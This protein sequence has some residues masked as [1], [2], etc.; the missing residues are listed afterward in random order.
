MDL[1]FRELGGDG[2]P[3]VI[4]H[5]LFGSSQNWA[6]M[7]RKLA[8][9][10]RVIAVDLRNHGDSPHAAP[11]SLDAC[12][13]DL[14]EWAVRHARGPLRLIGHSMGGLVAMGFALRHPGGA[15]GVAAIDIAPRAYPPGHETEL[16]ALRTDLAAC[17]TR[18]DLDALLAPVVPN[19]RV[20]Q[21]LLTNAVREG[22]GFR[23][24]IDVDVLAS[25]TVSADFAGREGAF[26]GEALLI[27]CGKSPY[28][29]PE[30]SAVM[31]RFFP[32]AHVEPIP[33]ADH[34]PNVTAP[35]ELETILR[36]FLARCNNAAPGPS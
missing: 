32:R 8:D 31:R 35:G 28:V 5:G 18:A 16:R 1:A 12:V 22:S 27:P 2:T 13:E 11:H 36:G 6:G 17:R 14:W 4:L 21:F 29:R 9:T 26:P 23:W 3:V 7:G 15:A 19:V 10:G 30:D 25:S 33:G 20:R 34:W 24:R